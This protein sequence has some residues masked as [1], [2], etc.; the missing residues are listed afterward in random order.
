[1]H[2]EIFA[3]FI[4]ELNN[5]DINYLILRGFGRLPD[6]PD[7]DID[8]VCHAAD[9][10]QFNKIAMQFLSKDPNEPFE[11]YGFAE[12]CDMLYHPYFTPGKKDRSISNGCFRVD[13]YNSI[14]FS[15]PFNN[16][17]SFWTVP[18]EFSDA[19]FADKAKF[20]T[21]Q[22]SCFIPKPEHE[23][24][25][26]VLRS[27]LDVIGWKK[28]QCKEKHTNRIKQ[29]LPH[30]D[31]EVLEREIKKVLPNDDYVMKCIKSVELKKLYDKIIGGFNNGANRR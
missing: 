7:S 29:L 18:L 17:K 9:W 16:F 19:V 3:R 10:E 14:Y 25:L 13:T 24:V 22:Y 4:K 28:K 21:S 2:K 20:K 12:Y 23:V 31:E 6:Y 15:S 8:L 5:S 30:C 27:L 11:N 1:M 26:L